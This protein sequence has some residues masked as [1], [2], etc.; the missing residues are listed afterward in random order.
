MKQTLMIH[1]FKEKY[2]SIPLQEYNLSFDDG[3]YSPFLFLSRL[4]ELNTPLIFSVSTSIICQEGIEQSEEIID[5]HHAHKKAFGGNFE[6]YMKWSQIEEIGRHPLCTIAGHGHS[7]I[8]V[9]KTTLYERISL[10]K[11]DTEGMLDR[12]QSMLGYIPNTFCFPY[13]YEDIVYKILMR[14]NYGFSHFLGK[15]RIDIDTM[16]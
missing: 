16:I 7:H 14:D 9:S 4:L 3:L 10:I 1:G 13:N 2:W 12:F 11:N 15:E 8:D 6:N 5:S